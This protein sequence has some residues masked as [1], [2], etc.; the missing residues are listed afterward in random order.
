MATQWERN[1]VMPVVCFK[2]LQKT[3]REKYVF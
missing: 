1:N 2:L 3:K